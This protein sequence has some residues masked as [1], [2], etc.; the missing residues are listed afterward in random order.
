M[1][2]RPDIDQ[3]RRRWAEI[4]VRASTHP[5]TRPVVEEAKALRCDGTCLVI[6]LPAAKPWLT[7]AANRR[8]GVIAAALAE[9]FGGSWDV[10]AEPIA[11]ARASQNP[12]E[13]RRAASPVPWSQGSARP[14]P[15][16]AVPSRNDAHWSAARI[17]T[18]RDSERARRG[19]EKERLAAS[20]HAAE[21][22]ERKAAETKKARE[23]AAR[24][25]KGPSSEE[26]L[27]RRAATEAYRAQQAESVN[28]ARKLAAERARPVGGGSLPSGP[29]D[30]REQ[31]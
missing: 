5:P 24:E 28:Y 29:N 27:A 23:R 3:V 2:P 1:T 6:G 7:D 16:P 22:A 25:R 12:S 14:R 4:V 17:P 11:P 8:A 20:L 26:L 21:D 19:L 10:R 18:S 15:V 31:E 13:P 30:W 9:T